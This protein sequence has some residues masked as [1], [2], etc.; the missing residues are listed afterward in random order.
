MS[1][2][3]IGTS[4]EVTGFFEE[5]QNGVLVITYYV[6]SIVCELIEVFSMGVQYI[7]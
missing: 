7:C 6:D 4:I 3:K 2:E 5:Y 1:I